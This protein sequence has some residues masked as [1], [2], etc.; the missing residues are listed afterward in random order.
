MSSV[1]V[2][3]HAALLSCRAVRIWL[4]ASKI[5]D[6][7]PVAEAVIKGRKGAK[8][9]LPQ[10]CPGASGVVRCC[11]Q[12]TLRAW[13]KMR[14]ESV[15]PPFLLVHLDTAVSCQNRVRVFLHLAASL[16]EKLC[17]PLKFHIM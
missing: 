5:H 6:F 11:E 12:P 17:V 9:A 13:V 4:F 16:G 8:L 1:Y 2:P 7:S 10:S 14:G 15:C 3:S